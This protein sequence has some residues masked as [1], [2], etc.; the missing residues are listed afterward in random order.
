VRP[1]HL[2]ER[3]VH[4]MRRRVV[5][6]SAAPLL[7]VDPCVDRVADPERPAL[8]R[9]EV[10]GDA[11]H[12]GPCIRNRHARRLGLEPAGVAHLTAGLRVERRAVEHD[13]SRLPGLEGLD[14]LVAAHDRR[15]AGA[16]GLGLVVAA[17]FGA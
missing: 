10:R 6:A 5:R 9:G 7:R 14:A 17:E 16:G 8:D 1:E 15:D 12:D 4:Q 3:G 2:L 11:G 13:L